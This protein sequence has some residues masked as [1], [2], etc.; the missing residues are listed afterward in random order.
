MDIDVLNALRSPV[1]LPGPAGVFLILLVLTWSLHILAVQ[2]MLGMITLSL[3]GTFQKGSHW[4]RLSLHALECGKVAVSIAIVLGVA[5]L[6]FVQ[7]IYDPFWYV[8]NVLSGRWVIASIFILLLG[9]YALYHG[10]FIK[11]GGEARQGWISIAVALSLLTSFG[12]IM[13]ALTSQMLTPEHWQQWYAPN[14][15]I[16]PRGASLHATNLGRFGY[17]LALSAP[18]TAAWLSGYARF[19]ETRENAEASAAYVNWLSRLYPPLFTTGVFLALVC[20]SVWMSTLPE[21]AKDFPKTGWAWLAI[22]G[23]LVVGIRPTSAPSYRPLMLAL[24]ANLCIAIAREA[25][26]LKIFGDHYGYE[27]SSYPVHLDGYGI[28][29]FIAT[30][31]GVGVPAIGYLVGTAWAFGQGAAKARTESHTLQRLG[32]LSLYGLAAWV[33]QYFIAGLYTLL[34]G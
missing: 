6:L 21:A 13:H 33:I 30:L 27:L 31:F 3:F 29:L 23:T 16:D 1:G 10:H 4:R 26:R 32:T 15:H 9:Y 24:V 28:F 12:W 19:L 17:F 34:R 5:P 11:K 18:V 20:Y 25:L 8:S 14:G 7:V 2:I 22:F